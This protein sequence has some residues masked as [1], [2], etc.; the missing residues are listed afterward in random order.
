MFTEAMANL[1]AD[2]EFGLQEHLFNQ[3]GSAD[4][5]V[6][7]YRLSGGKV[8][9]VTKVQFEGRLEQKGAKLVEKLLKKFPAVVT[10]VEAWVTEVG[11]GSD[12][13]RK[14]AVC[15]TVH[16][17]AGIWTM[18]CPIER[19]PKP[20]IVK[21]PLVMPERITGRMVD[22]GMDKKA[23][24]R[25]AAQL[26][27][28]LRNG[29]GINWKEE[30]ANFLGRAVEEA[31][32][33]QPVT[34]VI[35]E[36]DVPR[37][38]MKV[39]VAMLEQLMCVR[40]SGEREETDARTADKLAGANFSLTLDSSGSLGDIDQILL[41]LTA[42]LNAAF[43]KAGLNVRG[44]NDGAVAIAGEFIPLSVAYHLSAAGARWTNGEDGGASF[45]SIEDWLDKHLDKDLKEFLDDTMLQ[46]LRVTIPLNARFEERVNGSLFPLLANADE[47]R[48][49]DLQGLAE[50]SAELI[51]SVAAEVALEQKVSLVFDGFGSLFDQLRQKALEN[52]SE[53]ASKLV[54]VALGMAKERGHEITAKDLRLVVGSVE[55]EKPV[56]HESVMVT[57]WAGDGV[58]VPYKSQ[59]IPYWNVEEYAEVVA[60]AFREA[61]VL[62][63]DTW[64]VMHK[65]KE[66]PRDSLNALM[67]P[68][69]QGSWFSPASMT[70]PEAVGVLQTLSWDFMRSEESDD[71]LVMALP[72]PHMLQRLGA[73]S[74]VQ[75]HFTPAV[76]KVF[77]E[78]FSRDDRSI[79]ACWNDAAAK[80]EG[81]GRLAATRESSVLPPDVVSLA[82]Q[83]QW[84]RAPTLTVRPALVETLRS[85]DF[86]QKLPASVIAAPFKLQYVH[87]GSA[88]P[89]AEI[90]L[91]AAETAAASMVLVGAFVRQYQAAEGRRLDIRMV[92]QSSEEKKRLITSAALVDAF[93]KGRM[94][95]DCI[96][97][98]VA[99][100]MEE[101]GVRE[102]MAVGLEE[103]VKV[104]FYTVSKNARMVRSD[105]RSQALR[106]MGKKSP[107]QQQKMLQRARGLI[108]HILIGPEKTAGGDDLGE[109]STRRQTKVTVRR[110]HYHGYW[111]GP[112]RTELVIHLLEPIIVNKHLLGEGDEPPAPKN[113]TVH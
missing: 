74:V 103:I 104:L 113:Y 76:Y 77:K 65:L 38:R 83:L 107:E 15:I 73:V 75:R 13:V 17:G 111:T 29:G 16:S 33:L 40:R 67:F 105:E 7:G 110:G 61:G 86:S 108:D 95:N 89:V 82:L 31:R 5:S 4:Q 2:E 62:Q 99:S 34:D 101:G 23:L 59:R 98:A 81:L 37:D 109:G 84:S 58:C 28:L 53:Q 72:V 45:R 10:T 39:A 96:E 8:S 88:D 79:E 112:G 51:A 18:T 36:P 90:K 87:F 26:R 43:M 47:D 30:L 27:S 6:H 22:G 97:G 19:S 71:A 56:Q 54:E 93:D 68:D 50:R 70:M 92:W 42:K 78:A 1:V 94:V 32:E 85:V 91:E 64:P 46:T 55:F 14:E 60:N 35:Y 106:D 52:R 100:Q 41:V 66:Q 48:K 11:P 80:H 57:L 25:S 3:F 9:A 20:H 12:G 102:A 44:H 49:S 24:A 21:G 63:V 69:A